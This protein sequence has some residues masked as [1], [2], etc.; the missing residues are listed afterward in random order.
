MR[1]FSF[2]LGLV[3]AGASVAWAADKPPKGK[4]PNQPPAD[5]TDKT[6]AADP[7]DSDA[8][9][10][11]D[12]VEKSIAEQL[13]AIQTEFQ[14][15]Q[16]EMVKRYRATEDQ[17]ERQK[18][19]QEFKLLQADRTAKYLN[20][21]EKNPVDPAV[22]PALQIL[23]LDPRHSTKALDLIVKHHLDSDQVGGVC[24]QLG[25]RGNP[26][27]E[28]L[29]RE[30]IERSKSDDARGLAFLA[31]GKLLSA[32][33]DQQDTSDANRTK[34]REEAKEALTTVSEKYAD[35][36]ASG[37]NAGEWAKSILFEVEHLA[38]G[39]PVPDL[40]GQDLEGADFK[41]SDYRGK[42][43]FLDFWAHW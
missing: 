6:A 13:E 35:L 31:L 33:A 10:D 16:A 2:A 30:V 23:A 32:R 36:D 1:S 4:P 18:I 19:L 34:L 41:L 21:V 42:V 24:L 38:I 12:A 28:K 14:E 22:F 17:A 5:T 15:K 29:I 27:A 39:L 26:R 3:L 8:A 25:M 37:R 7:A 43:V 20:I 9:A 40:A 11:K